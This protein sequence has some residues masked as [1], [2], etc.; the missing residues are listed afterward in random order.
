[1]VQTVVYFDIIVYCYCYYYFGGH[2]PVSSYM[3]LVPFMWGS[4]FWMYWHLGNPYF[5]NSFSFLSL[6]WQSDL[7]RLFKVSFCMYG[8]V[9]QVLAIVTTC[10]VLLVIIYLR[11]VLC[12]SW[13]VFI[14]SIWCINYLSVTSRRIYCD[15]KS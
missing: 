12:I 10:Y 1:M 7:S 8:C 15:V 14:F 6:S 11:C 3:T 5:L 9:N 2:F 13:V 4:F